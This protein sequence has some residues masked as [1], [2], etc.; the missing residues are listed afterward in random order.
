[1]YKNWKFIGRNVHP[2]A[3]GTWEIETPKSYYMDTICLEIRHLR[4]IEDYSYEIFI[5]NGELSG[6]TEH[7][8]DFSA[9][10]N[11]KTSEWFCKMFMKRFDTWRKFYSFVKEKIGVDFHFWDKEYKR[12]NLHK[13]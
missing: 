6:V 1:M 3:R 12:K 9:L 5:F 7:F 13:K 8:I 2:V 4:E 11:I 10:K